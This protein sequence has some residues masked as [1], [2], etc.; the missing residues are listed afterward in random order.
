MTSTGEHPAVKFGEWLKS[1]RR[2]SG[3]VARVFAGRIDLSPAQYAEVEAGIGISRWITQ[4]Q[5]GLIAIMLDL[6]SDG[7]AELNHKIYLAKEVNDLRFDEVFSRDQLTPVRCS[8]CG[9]EQIDES[10]RTAILD[11]VFKPLA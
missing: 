10:K 1:K 4:K 2:E 11:A 7:E 3:V 6:D 9:N 8:T 5:V